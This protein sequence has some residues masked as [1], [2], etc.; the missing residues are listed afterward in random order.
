M[1]IRIIDRNAWKRPIYFAITV[2]SENQIGLEP[3][4]STEGMAYRLV[5]TKGRR[6]ISVERCRRN[7]YEVYRYRGIK[8]PEVY[9]DEY[10]T[11]LLGNYRTAFFLLAYAY[12]QGGAFDQA[13]DTMQRGDEVI[14][15]GWDGYMAAAEMAQKAGRQQE[16]TMYLEKAIEARGPTDP[17]TMMEFAALA[18]LLDDIPRTVAL[19]RGVIKQHPM[20]ARAYCALALVLEEQGDVPGAMEVLDQLSARYP[21]HREIQ[22]AIQE[23]RMR[24]KE[25]KEHSR[26]SLP[27]LG[28]FDGSRRT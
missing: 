5:K 21:G 20:L 28:G 3:Y 7:L 26:G 11:A 13:M 24:F 25:R 17:R 14:E 10:A 1:I 18:Y 8:D 4:L 12:M 27:Y 23:L 16:G 2:S 15:L 19:Y 22:R 6:Q 9:K